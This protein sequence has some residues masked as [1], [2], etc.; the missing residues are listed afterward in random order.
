M[1]ALLRSSG[2]ALLALVLGAAPAHARRGAP[3]AVTVDNDRAAPVGLYVDGIFAQ[4]VPPG[5]VATLRL[6]PGAHRLRVVDAQGQTLQTEE[7]VLAPH[8]TVALV[9]PPP[10][11]TLALR[12]AS[13]VPLTVRVEGRSASQ[14]VRRAEAVA[15]GAALSVSLPPGRYTVTV[16]ARWFGEAVEV[17]RHSLVLDGGEAE[18]LRLA[19]PAA[20]LVQVH[21]P[22]PEPARI[23]HTAGRLVHAL[24]EVPAEGTVRVLVPVGT[25]RLALVGESGWRDQQQI[26]VDARRGGR[27]EARVAVG[28]VA[29]A[30]RGRAPLW[31]W[32][33][34]REAGSLAAE[35]DR[36][37]ALVAGAHTV[38]LVDAGGRTVATQRVWVEEDHAVELAVGRPPRSQGPGHGHDRKRG[39]DRERGDD[40]ARGHSH[41]VAWH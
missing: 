29:L 30:N 38:T 1:S 26:R 11:A 25:A 8:A 6:R 36:S 9:V 23:L 35:S 19:T 24:G 17:D 5:E 3:A 20:A 34:D 16:W 27:F 33:D 32:V 21:N 22:A 18:A 12:S 40:R 28:T 14:R 10:P 31:V 13:S 4:E 7:A 37:L 15:P 39:H 2:A 41:A